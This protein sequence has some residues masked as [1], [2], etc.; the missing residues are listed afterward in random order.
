MAAHNS[1][2][3]LEKLCAAS[4]MRIIPGCLGI[5]KRSSNL[6]EVKVVLIPQRS[7]AEFTA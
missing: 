2:S 1:L 5:P 3:T 7:M 6:S 4:S